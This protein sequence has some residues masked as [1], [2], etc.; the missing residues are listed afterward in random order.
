MMSSNNTLKI[1]YYCYSATGNTFATID[2]R[3]TDLK[4][5]D[6]QRYLSLAKKENVDGLLFLK[7]AEAA[8]DFSM[9]YLNRDGREVEMCGNGLRALGVF[10]LKRCGFPDKEF[11]KVKTINA[12]YLMSPHKTPKVLMSERYDQARYQIDDLFSSPLSLYINTGVPHC[13]YQV[14]EIDKL[15]LDEIAKPI[16]HHAL[17]PDGCN[18]NFFEISKGSKDKKVKV[19][20]FE[21][22]VEAET[23][24]CGTGIT[25]VAYAIEH[26][27]D[28]PIT[29]ESR[30]GELTISKDSRAGLWLSGE[31]KETG[32]GFLEL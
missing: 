20:T 27:I 4:D 5:L 28:F 7:K 22:G 26:L 15:K 18:V 21:R 6:S 9:S 12:S 2:A 8:H 17:F 19:R 11:Y 25:A 30:G 23:L 13:V 1:P 29:F 14:E 31:V 3:E 16:R 32:S 10:A 24:S